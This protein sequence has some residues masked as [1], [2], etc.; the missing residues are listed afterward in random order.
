[1]AQLLEHD[2]IASRLEQLPAWE[3]SGHTITKTY[4]CRNFVEAVAFV[5]RIADA[6]EAANH[7][8]DIDIR[9][10]KVTLALTTHSDGGLTP[11]DFELANGIENLVRE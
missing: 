5:N 10:N 6:A 8:P 2:E 1:M 7:H 3:R 9:Y 11:K 4:K